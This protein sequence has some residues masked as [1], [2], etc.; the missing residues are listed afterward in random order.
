MNTTHTLI[1]DTFVGS[2]IQFGT[3]NS[4]PLQFL[5]LVD[6]SRGAF[7]SLEYACRLARISHAAVHLLYINDINDFAES[8]NP[9]V[10]QRLIDQ[11]E[12]KALRSLESL[13]EMVEES[14]VIVQSASNVTGNVPNIL[15][16]KIPDIKPSLIVIPRCCCDIHSLS[17]L[18]RRNGHPFLIIPDDPNTS[19]VPH[20]IFICTDYGKFN[21]QILGPLIKILQP[22]EAQPVTINI[23]RAIKGHTSNLLGN[24]SGLQRAI[25]FKVY[26]LSKTPL[27]EI[28]NTQTGN[29]GFD[30][31]VLQGEKPSILKN[32]FRNKSQLHIIYKINIP[33]LLTPGRP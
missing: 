2:P 23:P 4:K 1:P 15:T 21:Q 14:G 27:D 12:K 24:L 18:L 9:V 25:R 26:S 16:K 13:Q 19:H 6:A 32:I 29:H 17:Q 31:L 20:N 11:A 33:T 30:L 5:V 22:N 10:I 28:I 8:D 7:T 3:G